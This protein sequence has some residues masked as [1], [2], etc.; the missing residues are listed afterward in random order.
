MAIP[1]EALP[2]VVV[3]AASDYARFSARGTAPEEAVTATDAS[4]QGRAGHDCR[5]WS[6]NRASTPR[7]SGDAVRIPTGA[8]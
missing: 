4:A 6:T 2:N 8:P 3:T 7:H 1:N 5:S